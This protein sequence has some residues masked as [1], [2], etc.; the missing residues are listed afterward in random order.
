MVH[1]HV[2]RRVLI[3]VCLLLGLTAL[4]NTQ[5]GKRGPQEPQ[6]LKEVPTTHT[7][8][9]GEPRTALVIGNATY[10]SAPLKNPVNDASAIATAR[11]QL[12]F[13]VVLLRN[14]DRRAMLKAIADL[15]TKLKQGGIGLFFFAGHGLQV[16]GEN[17]LVPIEAP[18]DSD[19]LEDDMV[20]VQWVID[21][22]EEAKNGANLLILDACRDNPFVRQTRSGQRGLAYMKAPLGTLVAF[23]ASRHQTASDGT[24]PNGL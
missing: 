4:G 12:G 19:T 15:D 14:A 6:G 2:C 17:Y 23:A 5:S 8:A 1:K 21:R 13:K 20:L 24:G 9:P 11:E 22:M 7:G 10:A 18:L 3:T 16:R